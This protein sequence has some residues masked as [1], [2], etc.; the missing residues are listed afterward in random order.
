MRTRIAAFV[1]A[2]SI[3]SAVSAHATSIVASG[4]TGENGGYG[5]G[6]SF[7]RD[8]NLIIGQAFTMG[9][10]SFIAD[11]V[12]VWLN[13][14][15]GGASNEAF[16]LQIMDQVGAGATAANV[17]YTAGGTFPDSEGGH[18]P[19]SFSGIN[20]ALN[21]GTTYYL[22]VSSSA[23]Q[24]PNGVGGGHGWGTVD[25]GPG[26]FIETFATVGSPYVGIEVG[27]GLADYNDLNENATGGRTMFAVDGH[28][29]TS[30]SEV[31]EPTTMLLTMSG[32]AFVVRRRRVRRPSRS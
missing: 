29:P 12:T 32:L 30:L 21:A 17:L 7:A 26:S 24:N 14:W 31:P 23:G 27:G 3:G 28:L 5:V 15:E 16:T 22:V 9:G 2:L 20:I 10:T 4:P 25:G 18:L 1:L 13:D 19:V 6:Y 8:V 11:Q